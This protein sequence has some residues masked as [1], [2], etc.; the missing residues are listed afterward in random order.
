MYQLCQSLFTNPAYVELRWQIQ[1][2]PEAH[3]D[4]TIH[5]ELIF[6]RGKVWL[7]TRSYFILVLLEEFHKTPLGGNIGI[8]KTLHRLQENFLWPQMRED[9]QQY[10][11]QCLICQQMKYETRKLVELLQHLPTPTSV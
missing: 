6:I 10:V 1:Q 3:H 2:T 5:Q 8:A 7:P 4:F 9:I 11:S